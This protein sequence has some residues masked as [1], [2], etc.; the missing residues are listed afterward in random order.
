VRKTS[1]KNKL[2]GRDG[3]IVH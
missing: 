2:E 1:E 3:R